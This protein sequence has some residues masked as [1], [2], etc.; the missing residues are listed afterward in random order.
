[1]TTWLRLRMTHYS[2][3]FFAGAQNDDVASSGMTRY[4]KKF[5]AGAQNDDMASP[6]NDELLEKIL[7]WRSE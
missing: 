1:M 2:K 5:F 6:Q 3:R 4:S 7:R